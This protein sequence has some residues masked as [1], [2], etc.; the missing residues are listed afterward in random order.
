MIIQGK[1]RGKKALYFSVNVFS[2]WLNED[3]IFTSPTEDGTAIL[4][5]NPRH[6]KVGKGTYLHFSV[7]L[8]PWVSIRTRESNPWPLAL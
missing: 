3:I 1:K 4:R 7:I 8:R 5:G 2:K 6:A